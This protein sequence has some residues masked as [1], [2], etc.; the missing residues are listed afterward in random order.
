MV[1]KGSI[2]HPERLEQ[3]DDH[4]IPISLDNTYTST[5]TLDDIDTFFGMIFSY[6]DHKI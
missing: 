1:N 6:N 2:V 3:I 4:C 5:L